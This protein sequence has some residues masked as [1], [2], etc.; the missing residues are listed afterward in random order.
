MTEIAMLGRGV[1][2]MK[3]ETLHSFTGIGGPGK[4]GVM[5]PDLLPL[6]VNDDALFELAKAMHDDGEAGQDFDAKDDN[7]RIP[8][9]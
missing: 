3:R 8:A 6:H 5:F 1:R 7:P 9:G 4:F 2:G